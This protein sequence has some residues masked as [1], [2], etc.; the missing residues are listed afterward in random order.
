MCA[1]FDISYAV[2]GCVTACSGGHDL[3]RRTPWRTP[4]DHAWTR[5]ASGR[6]RPRRRVSAAH[7]TAGPRRRPSW[8]PPERGRT[9][10][11]WAAR[12]RWSAPRPCSHNIDT[13]AR[14][15]RDHGV[16]LYPHGKTTMS[17]QV[18]AAQ[19][20]AGAGGVT[21]ATVAQLRVFHALGLGPVLSRTRSSTRPGDL[22]GRGRWPR[23]R[24]WTPPATST[25]SR[26][27]QAG[28]V[29]LGRPGCRHYS[30]PRVSWSSWVTPMAVREP[31]PLDEAAA[32]A[33]AGR[34]PR[35]S[36]SSAW[37]DTKARSSGRSRRRRSRGA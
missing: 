36:S 28:R 11:G 25:A 14:Y 20:D 21:V 24:T 17:P 16:E 26:A 7:G 23:P 18:V 13:M 10:G 31:A 32:V 19:L 33:A 12:A 3:S 6:S 2:R 15:C 8:P 30:A 37:R 27:E 35:P 9:T 1:A 4:A 5:C 34:R 29:R 22:A